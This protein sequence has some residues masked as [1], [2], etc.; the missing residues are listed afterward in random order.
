MEYF[1]K[2]RLNLDVDVGDDVVE[3]VM[4]REDGGVGGEA[5]EAGAGSESEEFSSESNTTSTTNTHRHGGSRKPGRGKVRQ[6]VRS[7][8]PRLRWTHDLHHCFVLAVERLG[9]QESKWPLCMQ[10][11]HHRL[12]YHCM[13]IMY[14]CRDETNLSFFP[15]QQPH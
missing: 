14:L 9:G 12:H 7:R 6:Y 1:G 11:S 5:G 2:Q 13:H 10:T 4:E 15:V 3:D 8:L